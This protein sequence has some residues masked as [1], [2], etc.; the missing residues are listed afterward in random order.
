MSFKKQ[1]V[2]EFQTARIIA[3]HLQEMI[4]HFLGDASVA[5]AVTNTE[6]LL[7]FIALVIS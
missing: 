3:L 5:S 1:F 6:A 7:L 4:I 2:L